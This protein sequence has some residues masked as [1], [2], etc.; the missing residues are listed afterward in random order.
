MI[1]PGCTDEEVV[2]DRGA[3]TAVMITPD[4][5][6]GGGMYDGGGGMYDGGALKILDIADVFYN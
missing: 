5:D 1:T 3:P 2:T 6:G 4:F